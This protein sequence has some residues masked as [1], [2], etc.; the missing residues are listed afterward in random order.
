MTRSL[1]L[2]FFILSAFV[3][4]SAEEHA[5]SAHMSSIAGTVIKEPGSQPLKK[6][7]VQVVAE[8]QKEGGDYTAST[9]ADGHFHIEN[10]APGRYRIFIEKTGFVG[11]N[12][13]GLKSDVNVFTVQAGQAME[14]L[15][16]RMVP[17]AVI[18]GRITDEDGDP[19]SGVRVIALKKKPGKSTRESVGTEATN[20]LGEYRVAGLFPGQYWIVA[21][22]PVDFR[23]YEKQEKSLTSEGQPDTRYVNTYYPGTYDAMQAS[24]VTLKAG[25]EMPVNFTLVPARTYRVRG[26]ITGVTAAQKPSVELFS[27]AGDSYRANANEVGP[28]GQFEVRG[29]APGSY[30]VRA[31][32]PTESQSFTAR[33]DVS[34]VAADVEGV[35]LTPQSSFTLSGHLRIEGSA[36][37]DLTQYSANLRQAELP[38]DPGFFMSQEF[39]GT[40]APVDR[41]GNFEWKNVNPGN[42]IVQ[43]YGGDGQGFFLKSVKLGGRDIATGFTAGGP[44]T[45][46]LLVSTKG[47]TVEG[48]VVDA[49]V[50]KAVEKDGN[51]VHPVADATVVAVPEEKYRKLPD[52][53]GIGS[54]DQH[55]HFTIRGVAPGSYTIYA[56]QDL[57]DGV[58][59]DADFLKSQEANGTAVK[60]EEGSHQTVELKLSP[61]SEEWK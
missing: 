23:D 60:V 27:K 55:G 3:F 7:L 57:E 26:I 32:T 42:Y 25:D 58:W 53:F 22:P 34:V 12:G 43:V 1:A 33:Q 40:N 28:D 50:E 31:S 8:N 29:V 18:S 15:L 39:F 48:A 36:A 4:A 19:M 14:D 37:A 10:V 6:V 17:T 13:H 56:W 49:A 41:L 24:A 21:M 38:E 47:G 52:R 35:K 5:P 61:T 59:R 2:G 45:L 20:D 9:D 46:D 16:F 51:E 44:A 11:V 54:T 30:V